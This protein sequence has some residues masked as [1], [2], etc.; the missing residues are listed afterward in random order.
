MLER[1]LSTSVVSTVSP[2]LHSLG[3]SQVHSNDALE[4]NSSALLQAAL[5]EDPK[6]ALYSTVDPEVIRRKRESKKYQSVKKAASD[7]DEEMP[8]EDNDREDTMP[9]PV[10]PLPLSTDDEDVPTEEEDDTTPKPSASDVA[11]WVVETGHVRDV[12]SNQ[13]LS[14]S[15]EK[16]TKISFVPGAVSSP[17]RPP[18]FETQHV[19]SSPQLLVEEEGDVESALVGTTSSPTVFVT[20]E[21][22]VQTGQEEPASGSQS[23]I[24]DGVKSTPLLLSPKSPTAPSVPLATSSPTLV[25]TGKQEPLHAVHQR[26]A[27]TDTHSSPVLAVQKTT[28]VDGM[29]S[30]P[31]ILHGPDVATLTASE[32]GSKSTVVIDGDVPSSRRTEYTTEYAEETVEMHSVGM[33]IDYRYTTEP[34]MVSPL[35]SPTRGYSDG[36]VVVLA[37]DSLAREGWKEED[38]DTDVQR[39]HSSQ[40]YS[41]TWEQTAEHPSDVSQNG[42]STIRFTVTTMVDPSLLEPP[43]VSPTYEAIPEDEVSTIVNSRPG[44]GG[45]P[46]SANLI[47]RR[48]KSSSLEDF[49]KIYYEKFGLKVRV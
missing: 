3:D 5:H 7:H 15:Y 41:S 20:M 28:E 27:V 36:E 17:V 45:R 43:S 31:D 44:S 47:V 49:A 46:L 16:V 4:S 37:D 29:H 24:P 38:V 13:E 18:Q 1:S 40:Q 8:E 12:T 32:I 9:P 23:S 14:T 2:I 6:F 39:S 26:L 34:S 19:Q 33:T 42:S 30:S 21:Q 25:S 35:T 22:N 48:R 10:P 11:S